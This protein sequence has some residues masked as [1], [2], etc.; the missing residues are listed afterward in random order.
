MTGIDAAIAGLSGFRRP[1]G[2]VGTRNHV[3]VVPTVICSSVVA[4]RIAAAP[5]ASG[6]RCRTWRAAGSSAPTCGSPTRRWPP[7][8]SIP[9]SAPCS[10]SRSDASRWWRRCW[11]R[12]RGGRQAGRDRRDP[13]GGRHVRG[14]REGRAHRASVRR[15]T[16]ASRRR[17]SRATSSSSSCRSSAAARTTRRASRRIPTLGRVTD[18]L[19][20]A[21]R[22]ARCSARSPRSWAPNTCSP[23]A[24][25]ARRRPRS[26]IQVITRVETEARALGLDIRG[27][28]PS[29]GN[30]RGGLTTIEEKSLG[31]DAQGRRASAARRRRR[32]RRAASRGR[33]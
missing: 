5:P 12:P 21:R 28:Q 16:L 27:T 23:R 14:D 26:C 3:L 10:S 20:D 6:P 18:R 15:A 11:P 24:R 7:T 4:E 13:G 17:A 2:R 29:P 22:G 19:V 9:T 25:R 30:I 8:A 33:G 32:L 31:R 1:D